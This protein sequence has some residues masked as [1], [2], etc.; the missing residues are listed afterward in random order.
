M[1][2]GFEWGWRPVR[3]AAH[4]GSLP[5]CR[6]ST[7]PDCIRSAACTDVKMTWRNLTIE[8]TTDNGE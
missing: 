3:P 6:G 4:V 1:A 8:L 5:E 2:R 7:C